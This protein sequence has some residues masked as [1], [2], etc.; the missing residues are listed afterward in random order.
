MLKRPAL[1]CIIAVLGI[2]SFGLGSRRIKINKIAKK[3]I[4]IN[5]VPINED[6]VPINEDRDPIKNAFNPVV[7][8]HAGSK[9]CTGF[10][11][12]WN[13]ELKVVTAA[14]CLNRFGR[15]LPRDVNL[16]GLAGAISEALPTMRVTININDIKYT[17]MAYPQWIGNEDFT[18]MKFKE[19]D[20]IRSFY[21]GHGI[22][23][24]TVILPKSID[25]SIKEYFSD[26]I[27][28]GYP[29]RSRTRVITRGMLGPPNALG[30]PSITSPIIKGNSG[31]PVMKADTLEVLGVVSTMAVIN[32]TH[33]GRIYHQYV[34]HLGY[35]VSFQHVMEA[36]E[37]IRI[38]NGK[39]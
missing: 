11:I 5:I 38:R 8:V 18:I 4:V 12:K 20:S 27:T 6:I 28:V 39:N 2:V 14:H 3:P 34:S 24:T 36:L 17:T 16:T 23:V 22:E 9:H 25:E 33:K 21:K 13:G 31:G 26:I 10:L 19:P 15:L 37:K 7:I 32:Y 29:I 30:L 35:M 1:F